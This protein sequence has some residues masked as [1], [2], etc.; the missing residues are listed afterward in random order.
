MR[1]MVKR[2]IFGCGNMADEAMLQGFANLPGWDPKTT[3]GCN[4]ARP[5]LRVQDCNFHWKERHS[6]LSGSI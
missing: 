4:R 3:R 1:L 5:A 6:Q 2:G